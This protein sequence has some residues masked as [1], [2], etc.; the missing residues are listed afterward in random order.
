MPLHTSHAKTS[1]KIFNHPDRF[2]QGWYW[3]IRSSDLKIGAVKPL[4]L[5]GKDLAVY[6]GE[7]GV[8]IAIDAYC[9]HMGAH[10]AE[11]RV[12]GN[13]IRCFFHNWKFDQ[14][15]ACTEMPCVDHLIPVK[16][17]TYPTTE[18]YGMVWIW[19]GDLANQS[20]PFVPELEDLECE[21]AF[22]D[23]FTKKCHPNVMM[24]NA[25][26]AN[27]FNTVHNFP[28]EI[29]FA[30]RSLNQNAIAFNNT[31]RGGDDSLLVKLVRRFYKNEATYNMSYWF[32]STGTVTL[33][34][35][36]QHFYLMFALRMLEGG[37]T[38]GQT[39]LITRKRQGIWGWVLSQIILW[40][41]WLVGNYFAKGDTKIFQTIKFDLK[42]PTKA[43]RS[44]VDFISH[45][46]TQTSIAWETWEVIEAESSPQQHSQHPDRIPE[47]VRETI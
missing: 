4:S 27:H 14:N 1:L 5:M 25:I 34:P 30:K 2:I 24:I 45:V 8:V 15:G 23:R 6:R 26:D 43:D 35:D 11:G 31:T 46:E 20:V 22:G 7:D 38:E 13:S 42:T 32:G 29:E 47:L 39:I 18:K 44:I 33:G 10:L 12:E 21:I 3:A 37:Q 28:I 36:F 19:T 16:S 41:T 9:P 40:L 17:N